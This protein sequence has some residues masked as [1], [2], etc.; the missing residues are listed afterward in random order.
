MYLMQVASDDE[1]TQQG[2]L[3]FLV[4]LLGGTIGGGSS[5]AGGDG[6]QS[7]LSSQH[8]R[9]HAQLLGRIFRCAPVRVGAIHIYSSGLPESHASISA[10]VS[11]LDTNERHRT[12]IHR[13]TYSMSQV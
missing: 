9:P 2:G 8:M 4:P 13:G 10:L 11:E 3:V 1:Q 5:G 7:A 12:R 6:D